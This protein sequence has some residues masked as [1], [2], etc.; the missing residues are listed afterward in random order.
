MAEPTFDDL[1]LRADIR[2]VVGMLGETLSRQ[3]GA[4]LLDLVEQV[5]SGTRV[6]PAATAAM[7]DDVDVETA[8]E[9][10]RAFLAYFHLANVVEQVH[11]GRALRSV[12][13]QGGWL[14]RVADAIEAS[15]IDRRV[16]ADKAARLAVRP[17]FT[18]H[19]TE[20]ARRTTLARLRGVADLLE[21]DRD[22]RADRQL[23]EIIDL[24]WLTDDLRIARPEPIDE[25]RNAIYYFDEL[26]RRTV[27]HVLDEL[28]GTLRRLGVD[29]PPIARPLSFG[30]WIGGDRDGNPNVTPEVTLDVIR[31]QHDHAIRDAIEVVDGLR[32]DLAVSTRLVEVSP[33]LLRSLEADLA[34]LPE[35][36][37]RY[38]RLNAEE[39]YRL[40]AI[41]IRQKLLNTQDR[42]RDSSHRHVRGRDYLGTDEL[43]G[44]LV[45]MRDSLLAN[46]GELVATGRLDRAI[47]TVAAFGLQ[48]ATMDVRE[49][50]EFHHRAVG[51]LIERLGQPYST[52]T[53]AER[54]AALGHELANP[55]PLAA[56]PPPLAESELRTYRVFAT[57]REA[58]DN[59]GPDV[60]QTYIV[61]M[62]R[63]A[64]DVLAAVVLARQAGL[65]DIDAGVAGLGF[66]P[67]LE[68]VAELRSADRVLDDLLSV[69]A[70]RRLVEQRGN[71]QEVMLGYSDSNKEA[72]ITTSQWEIQRAQRR[73][74][75]VARRH[76]VRTTFFPGRG[77]TV[78][79]GGGPTHEAIMA[80]PNGSLDGGVKFTEQ[81]EVISDKYGLA[82]LAR[83]NLELTIAAA[84][85]ATVLH[86]TARIEPSVLERWDA[87]MDVVSDAAFAAYRGLIDDPALAAYFL[88]V[89]PVDQLGELHLGSRPSRRP[90]TGSGIE[91]LRAIPWVFGWTQSRHIVP[92]WFGVGS[93]L[94]AARRAGLGGELSAMHDG[95]RFF[96]NFLGNVEMTLMK[97]D[98]AV[99]ADYAEALVPAELRPVLAVIEGEYA[100]TLDEVLRVTGQSALL[101]G[102]PVLRRTLEIR[103]TYLAPLH[104]LQV[105]LLK[106]VRAATG[107][108]GGEL[109]R[110]LLLTINGIAAGLR[111]TG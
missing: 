17:V 98:L 90:D 102:N 72:G 41:C 53:A 11:R 58:Q 62:T 88:A 40:K 47:R 9:L 104:D 34:A 94:A 96:A 109:R 64:D 21:L 2:R 38:L 95:W 6:E 29:L 25:A 61:S 92:G 37:D 54:L 51:A 16:V 49:H 82:P 50:A 26:Y 68:T 91:G 12:R 60:V 14:A 7:L 44:D 30:T 33:S 56:T 69:P 77:G 67:L 108:P 46:R 70:Y 35:V 80:L 107:E 75:E 15:G 84:L 110:A 76:G 71:E 13:Q 83:D 5:R 101:D 55:R 105:A 23:A 10:V 27:P 57:I 86:A 19:P 52:L 8:N 36:E 63:G 3:E 59:L 106:R 43:L 81:G 22:A 111:N 39:P 85:E 79:R 32:Q 65:V 20:A 48:L 99:A 31:L 73:L 4:E 45:A 42:I 18:A 28:D 1:A 24:L 89:T 87:A 93:G 78:G 66:V 74:L 103:A 100:R 97:T